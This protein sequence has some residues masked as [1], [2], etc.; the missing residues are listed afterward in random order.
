MGLG[1]DVK[2]RRWSEDV[3]GGVRMGCEGECGGEDVRGGV[4]GSGKDGGEGSTALN[5]YASKVWGPSHSPG[6]TKGYH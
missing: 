1:W 6:G 5:N 2:V 3:R 4:K